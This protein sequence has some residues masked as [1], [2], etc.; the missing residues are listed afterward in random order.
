MCGFFINIKN[1]NLGLSNV[2]KLH[3]ISK[4]YLKHRGPD[5]SKF[6][7]DKKTFLFHS[8]LSIQDP[9][10][11]SNQPMIKI[12]KKKKIILL[13]NGEI[14]NFKKLKKK[15]IDQINFSSNGDTE[16]LLNNFLV[17]KSYKNFL[18]SLD[19]MFSFVIKIGNNFFFARD[20]FGQKPLYYYQDKKDIFISSEIKP[21]LKSI[22]KKK[23]NL[24]KNN[25]KN[26]F[27]SNIFFSKD[28]TF[29]KDIYS[30]KAGEFGT[31]ENSNIT[32][33]SYYG[34]KKLINLKKDKLSSFG[35]VFENNILKHLIAD[36]KIAIALSGGID[37]Q[38][39]AHV[40]LSKSNI[41]KKV[42]N[43]CID[44][45]GYKNSEFKYAKRFADSYKSKIKKIS[46]DES[47]VINNFGKLVEKNEGPLG[48]IM[49]I[50]MFKLAEIAKN[51]GY[52]VLL[53][54]WGLDECLGSYKDL[55][56]K[57][58][59]KK[60][61]LIDGSDISNYSMLA[62]INKK[63]QRKK[64]IFDYFFKTKIPRTVHMCDRFSMSKSVE[65]RLPFLD[66]HF[67][68]HCLNI[69]THK[70]K[71]DKLIIREYMKKNSVC[72]KN[73]FERKIHVPHPQN[74]WLK[75]GKL[76][77]W[78]YSIINDDFIYKNLSFL[79]KKE[80]IKFWLNFKKGKIHS[81]YPIWQLL[82]IHFM[83]RMEKKFK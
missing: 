22:G 36:K 59:S 77:D 83:L 76:S 53:A 55:N 33:S 65:L 69:D 16:V 8:R 7:K 68:E 23:T 75:S 80:V 5:F 40:I 35:Q 79:S 42:I 29:F 17:N 43:Y 73:W 9:S 45:K 32:T 27:L 50:G 26:Y 6:V 82:N 44:F 20:R 39:L 11:N 58:V 71:I 70:S 14:Y 21:I 52:D 28:E 3:K 56:K 18:K 30:V 24:D 34:E 49:H 74:D 61:S 31:I 60:F 67:V 15:L 66:H 38:S 51:D 12:K 2:E 81:G 57:N 13:F 64:L 19:G 48:G 47:Y 25:L 46:I 1:K 10:K 72:K 54:G 63:D 62:D 4:K 37:S 78:A 41:S